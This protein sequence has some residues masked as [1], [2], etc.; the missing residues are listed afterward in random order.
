MSISRFVPCYGGL[1]DS[2]RKIV[3]VWGTWTQELSLV[4]D[5]RK[6]KPDGVID[7]ASVIFDEGLK[8][9]EIISLNRIKYCHLF[10]SI[11]VPYKVALYILQCYLMQYTL[12][13]SLRPNTWGRQLL[14]V[15]PSPRPNATFS[16]TL[17]WQLR[18]GQGSPIRKQWKY[19]IVIQSLVEIE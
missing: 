7:E 12:A 1:N 13:G 6:S 9:N 10:K 4:S 11:N 8:F 3:S 15:P 14:P 19:D 17:A 16:V 18:W 5:D 2:A